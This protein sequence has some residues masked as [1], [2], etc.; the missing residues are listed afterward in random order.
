MATNQDKT[1]GTST[2]STSTTGSSSQRVGKPGWWTDSHEQGWQ[3][4]S[5]SLRSEW[6]TGGGTGAV[7][8]S[9]MA[10]GTGMGSG[11]GSG[12]GSGSGTG[13]GTGSGMGS[14]TG[15]GVSGRDTGIS[16]ASGSTGMGRS[17][18][19]MGTGTAQGG[20]A[21]EGKGSGMGSVLTG[22]TTLGNKGDWSHIEP[23]MRYGH[24]AYSQYGKEHGEWNDQ[25]HDK[26]RSEWSQHGTSHPW[27]SIKQF[28][29]K[30]WDAARRKM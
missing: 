5:S 23:A 20:T 15:S 21:G 18:G 2:G 26:L 17:S 12:M 6:E 8:G 14:T 22:S 9:G 13:T 7:T 1:Q 29:R 3:K 24:G 4:V 19:S 11:T 25:V 28:V 16:S 27:E 30:G 10:S